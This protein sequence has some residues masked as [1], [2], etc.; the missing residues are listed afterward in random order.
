MRRVSVM[1]GHFQFY[2]SWALCTHCA[3]L[4]IQ[5]THD[6]KYTHECRHAFRGARLFWTV[7]ECLGSTYSLYVVTLHTQRRGKQRWQGAWKSQYAKER[8]PV[9]MIFSLLC[10]ISTSF[11]LSEAAPSSGGRLWTHQHHPFQQL[12]IFAL[13]R[14]RWDRD[15]V[16]FVVLDHVSSQRVWDIC[17]TCGMAP[18]AAHHKHTWG[19]HGSLLYSSSVRC[20]DAVTS[21]QALSRSHASPSPRPFSN[22]FPARVRMV[23]GQET[24][25]VYPRMHA[26]ILSNTQTSPSPG[27][28]PWWLWCPWQSLGRYS[29]QR[30]LEQ[31]KP[32]PRGPV[33]RPVST[34]NISSPTA[35]NKRRTPLAWQDR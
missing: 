14:C 23:R 18:P 4:S 35:A 2:W 7:A 19:W 24:D 28:V 11:A 17:S 6:S 31:E 9:C 12:A 20:E 27:W 30:P 21:Q 13:Q 29:C 33:H 5:F 32:M 34:G 3:I 25:N 15:P 1:L 26:C 22:A 10:S 16:G 8:V